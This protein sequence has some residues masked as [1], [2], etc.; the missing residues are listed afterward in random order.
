VHAETENIENIVLLS[1]TTIFWF[2]FEDGN[3]WD[4]AIHLDQQ[5]R[6]RHLEVCPDGE[7]VA[8]AGDPALAQ[9]FPP[10]P[11][12]QEI[13]ARLLRRI[14]L[15][16]Y[17]DIARATARDM[18]A[19]QRRRGATSPRFQAWATTLL[20]EP[21]PGRRGRPDLFY[22]QIASDYVQR[23]GTKNIVTQMAQERNFSPSYLSS[24]LNEARNR[25]LLTGTTRGKSGGT[26]TNK[27]VQLLEEAN[28]AKR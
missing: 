9:K 24:L 26:L 4:V 8:R 27:A 13:T 6:F 5:A 3:K 23:I 14:P 11:M 2:Q 12:T 28:S 7:W 15:G 25:C 19:R 1:D 21:R 17:I 18:A 20:D 10:E 16:E 22:A